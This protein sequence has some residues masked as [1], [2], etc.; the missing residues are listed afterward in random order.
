MADP[1]ELWNAVFRGCAAN[2]GPAVGTEL[3][4]D[5]PG[6]ADA[7]PEDPLAILPLRVCSG[8]REL[9]RVHLIGLQGELVSLG[10][11]SLGD[12]DPDKPRELSPKDFDA[13]GEVLSLMGAALEPALQERGATELRAEALPWWRS[14]EPGENQQPPSDA[15]LG[16]ATL[17]IPDGPAVRLWL[18]APESLL[19]GETP[20]GEETEPPGKVAL[21]ALDET[22][23]GGLQTPLESAGFEVIAADELSPSE[24]AEIQLVLFAAN[25][26]G[27]EACR[28]LRLAGR[29]WTLPMI[30]CCEEPTRERV[31]ALMRNGASHVLG[32]PA[33]ETILLRVVDEARHSRRRA[34]GAHTPAS[35]R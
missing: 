27:L 18:A 4:V 16:T 7:L 25:E 5:E 19:E 26:R 14:D 15:V 23:R 34:G 13:I 21:V 8:D 28:T 24:G 9:G 32:M 31:I 20:A 3:T 2:V 30:A 10:R 1:S 35:R 12:E 17:S 33:D 22:G 29:T 6:T 11:R